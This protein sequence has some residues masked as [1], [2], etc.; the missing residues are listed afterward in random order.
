MAVVH[1]GK[2]R[3][4]MGQRRVRMPMAVLGAGR[5]GF[6]VRMLVVRVVAMA[7]RMFMGDALMLVRMFVPFRQM[8][9]DAEH[10]QGTGYQ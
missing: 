3:M 9:P 5:H 8:Q 2:M 10:H 7:M 6:V 4:T 1:I